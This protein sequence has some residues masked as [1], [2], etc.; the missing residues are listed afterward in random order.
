MESERDR[1][2]RDLLTCAWLGPLRAALA[3]VTSHEAG[4]GGGRAVRATAAVV[5]VQ[6]LKW[7]RAKLKD[8]ALPVTGGWV[9]GWANRWW[10]GEKARPAFAA[11]RRHALS[12]FADVGLRERRLWPSSEAG[13]RGR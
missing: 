5:V 9:R 4:G 12:P 10:L 7:G 3:S 13:P 1:E 11:S 8:G 2:T 6:I